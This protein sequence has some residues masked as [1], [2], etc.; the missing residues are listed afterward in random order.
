M[1]E[2]ALYHH[3]RQNQNYLLE[4]LYK[5]TD[6]PELLGRILEGSQV[7]HITTSNVR[8]FHDLGITFQ[9]KKHKKNL[10]YLYFDV[11]TD[12]T[13][14]LVVFYFVPRLTNKLG[15]HIGDLGNLVG[16]LGQ[17][18]G[19]SPKIMLVTDQALNLEE[20]IRPTLEI[21]QFS[22]KQFFML[23]QKE[24]TSQKAT[25]SPI[26]F[27]FFQNWLAG[28]QLTHQIKTLEQ[29]Q[30]PDSFFEV[31]LPKKV[32]KT[33]FQLIQEVE[34][35][36]KARVRGKIT[37]LANKVFTFRVE[38]RLA[39][40]GLKT[41][42]KNWELVIPQRDRVIRKQLADLDLHPL[43]DSELI[44]D[45]LSKKTLKKLK[46]SRSRLRTEFQSTFENGKWVLGNNKLEDALETIVMIYHENTN[47]MQTND[48][49]TE[50][51]LK[52]NSA[53]YP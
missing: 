21:I 48:A 50:A 25:L 14:C 35:V 51:P 39:K 3:T 2:K 36:Q 15:R 43:N 47:V 32:W 29:L 5:S 33:K 6:D 28:W 19:Y 9:N 24:L 46:Q 1:T 20:E 41:W 37:H 31:K 34:G 40:R 42:H 23:L 49:P 30:I 8:S 22:T 16:Q 27:N 4:K 53:K 38:L 10:P 44:L 52:P 12:Q 7:G 11:R 18:R 13:S 26:E 17:E 45:N